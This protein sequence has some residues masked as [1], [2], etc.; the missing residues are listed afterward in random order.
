MGPVDFLP[1]LIILLLETSRRHPY[2]TQTVPTMSVSEQLAAIEHALAIAKSEN[3]K[4]AKGQ[5]AAAPKVRNSLLDIGKTC[6]DARKAVLDIGK[7]IPV[8]KRS[9]K[10]EVKADELV[11][12]SGD[13]SPDPQ[14]VAE[15][16]AAPAVPV[17]KPRAPRAKK[18]VEAKSG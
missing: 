15:A 8:K 10:L 12:S 9:P 16:V 6:S 7:G 3:E 17:K 1:S 2:T 5:K 13:E 18:V 11:P 4:L 14:P